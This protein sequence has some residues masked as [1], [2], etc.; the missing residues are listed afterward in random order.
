MK[1][2]AKLLTYHVVAGVAAFSKDL[3]NG[4]RIKTVE[5]MDVTV[6]ISAAGVKINNASV[7]TAN[8]AASNGVVHIIDT[9]LMPPDMLPP[10]VPSPPTPPSPPA[11]PPAPSSGNHLWFR[12][13]TRQLFGNQ[14]CRCG[15]V[16][17]ALRMPAS[18]FDPSNAKALQRYKDITIEFYKY[19]FA[20][21]L[22]KLEVGRCKDTTSK[23]GPF[24]IQGI[25]W[26]PGAL[27]SPICAEKCHC[28]YG[29]AG[30]PKLP[31]C[32]DRPDDPKAGEF[33]SLC[34]P[35]YNQPIMIDLYNGKCHPQE[36]THCK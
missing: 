6:G 4:E 1:T 33:C 30:T 8:V 9:V 26:A 16:D 14:L 27:M 17:A 25:G 36:L 28:T 22:S 10:P 35:K 23:D 7:T 19:A 34:G 31:Y 2:L 29:C 12:G 5:G 18:L 21:S 20:D 13:F 32:K 24:P 11:P 15:E 3:E